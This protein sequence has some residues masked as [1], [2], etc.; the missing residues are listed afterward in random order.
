LDEREE[1]NS[2]EVEEF[3]ARLAALEETRQSAQGK[4]AGSPANSATAGDG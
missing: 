1:A 2:P 3:R 4:A